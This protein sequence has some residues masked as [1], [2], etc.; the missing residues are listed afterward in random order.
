VSLNKLRMRARRCGGN[1]SMRLVV[2]HGG[3]LRGYR[4]VG[5]QFGNDGR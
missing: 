3:D 2:R 1:S 4:A 5:D